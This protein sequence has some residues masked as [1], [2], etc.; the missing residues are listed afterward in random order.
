MNLE[1]LR[2]QRKRDWIKAWRERLG[3]CNSCGHEYYALEAI[4]RSHGKSCPSCKL[5]EF[6]NYYYCVSHG[7]SDCK[8]CK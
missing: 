7:A 5:P 1:Q 6:V 8:D 3:Y 2:E 4:M